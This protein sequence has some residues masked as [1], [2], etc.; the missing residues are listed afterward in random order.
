MTPDLVEEIKKKILGKIEQKY[1]HFNSRIYEVNID[2]VV[3]RYDYGVF[4]FSIR[5]MF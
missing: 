3:I 2:S 4:I 5:K 1:K